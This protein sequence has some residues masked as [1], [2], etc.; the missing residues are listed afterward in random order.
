MYDLE[1]EMNQLY[2]KMCD[3]SEEEME[4]LLEETGEIQSELES[5][6]FYA[7][8]A[9]IEEVANG[10]GLGELGLDHDVAKWWTKV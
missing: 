10:L 1:K 4:E 8:E 6:G 5:S 2:E 3:C 9:K 7:L